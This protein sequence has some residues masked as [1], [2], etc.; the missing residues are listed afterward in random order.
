MGEVAK[1]GRTILFVSHNLAAV[2]GLCQQSVYL[3]E[4]HI[5]A[6]GETPTI[7]DL[8]SRQTLESTSLQWRRQDHKNSL[9]DPPVRVV[10]VSLLDA[11]V[12]VIQVD[13]PFRVSVNFIVERVS[14]FV[15][16]CLHFLNG[17][18]LILF[19]SADWDVG[20]LEPGTYSGVCHVPAFLL[21]EEGYGLCLSIQFQ[22]TRYERSSNRLD[23]AI[24]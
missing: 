7:L 9:K 15:I 22:P 24:D 6:I 17:E 11:T 21:N 14:S 8:Y 23:K 10:S 19:S 1:E 2:R 12:P 13:K 16:P 20:L 18:G 3:D 5:R 4:G